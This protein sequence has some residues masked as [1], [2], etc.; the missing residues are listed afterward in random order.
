MAAVFVDVKDA[1]LQRRVVLWQDDQGELVVTEWDA[2]GKSQYRLVDKLGPSA[3]PPP[4]HGT[5]L[6]AAASDKGIVHVV[7][8]DAE[9]VLTHVFEASPGEWTEGRVDPAAARIAASMGSPLSATWHQS[10][11]GVKFLVV[12][13][14]TAEGR[15][16]LALAS[17]PDGDAKW[18]TFPAAPLA[19]TVTGQTISTSL[20]VTGDWTDPSAKATPIIYMA[21]ED[22]TGLSG[23]ECVTDHWQSPPVEMRCSQ[24]QRTEQGELPSRGERAGRTDII[25]RRHGHTHDAVAAASTDYLDP[26]RRQGRLH[27]ARAEHR[28]RHPGEL[29]RPGQVAGKGARD[30]RGRGVSSDGGDGRGVRVCGVQGE[31]VHIQ[32]RAEVGGLDCTGPVAL[33]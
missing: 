24:T 18:E 10:K 2:G 26:A 9:H 23:Y 30:P 20:A 1:K 3:L 12:A 8:L 31:C 5:P 25:S 28:R 14:V 22:D 13:Y 6:A 17:D 33:T 19:H 27:P 16:R 7:F 32:A 15:I 21:L 29:H 4:K 11:Q